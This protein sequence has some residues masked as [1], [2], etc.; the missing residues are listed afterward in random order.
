MLILSVIKKK[1]KA[2]KVLTQKNI[3]IT[4]L[5]VLLTKLFASIIG[6][7]SKLLFLEAKM[8]LMNLLKQFSKSM[9]TAKK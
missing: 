8:L 1:L 6:L 9:S 4:F 2:M 3:K 5:V 7:V